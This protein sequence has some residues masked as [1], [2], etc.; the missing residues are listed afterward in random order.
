MEL[1]ATVAP[2]LHHR[3]EQAAMV[4]GGHGVGADRRGVAVHEVGAGI[5]GNAVEQGRR[6][7]PAQAVPAHVRNPDPRRR[8]QP[9][10]GTGQQAQAGDVAFLRAF[11]QQLHAQADAQQRHRQRAQGFHQA[12][13]VQPAHRLGR[14]THA[15]QDHPVGRL[16]AGGIGHHLRL[17][18]Q[19]LQRVAD[20]AEVG[21]TGIDHHHAQAGCAAHSTPLVEGRPSPWRVM[22]WR[23]ARASP[24]KLASI[25]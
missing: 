1:G 12:L 3:A 2:A 22:A 14:G 18:A 15:G 11:I 20:R 4:A 9:P 10:H 17:H 8:L 5:V 19:P 25:L 21:A 23:S 16:Q 24:L 13:R 6:P 7:Q